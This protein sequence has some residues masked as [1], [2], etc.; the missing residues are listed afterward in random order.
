MHVN[1]YWRIE[2]GYEKPT[3]TEKRAI[4]KVLQVS[5]SEAFPEVAA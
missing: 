1:R 2:N 3:D 5:E 4:L